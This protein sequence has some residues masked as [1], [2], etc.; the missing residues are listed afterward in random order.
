M[1]LP[2]HRL[3]ETLAV[4]PATL[5]RL[6]AEHF[7]I[8]ELPWNER[9][10]AELRRR[11]GIGG[12]AA[13]AADAGTATYV[14]G[15][16]GGDAAAG[17]GRPR[18]LDGAGRLVRIGAAIGGAET[19]WLLGAAAGGL[20]YAPEIA[21]PVRELDVAALHQIVLARVL[22]LPIGER[23]GTPGLSYTQDDTKAFEAVEKGSAA[24]A[25]FLPPTDVDALRRIG[26]A[27]LTM[28]EKS[29]YFH[30]KLL[31]GLVLYPVDGD[32]EDAGA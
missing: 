26:V 9:G 7:T 8:Q 27:G 5:R 6:L 24:A 16:S 21:A 29:T 13:D 30:P 15:A 14:A 28:P 19:L 4:D 2:T 1:I 18:P 11:L 32:P 31:T 10:K 23:G 3:L 25:F 20:P 22:R 17:G 12:E